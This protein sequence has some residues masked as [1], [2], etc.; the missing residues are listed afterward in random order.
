VAAAQDGEQNQCTDDGNDDRSKTAEAI[1]EESEHRLISSG[2]TTSVCI[3]E[4]WM[5]SRL[6][7]STA[8][9]GTSFD[10]VGMMRWI[11]RLIV[12]TV[13]AKLVNR[14]LGSRQPQPRSRG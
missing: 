8:R 6:N 9:R 7:F 11:F 4:R 13:A 1:G 2:D 10:P 3:I 14:Y 12:M 5:V